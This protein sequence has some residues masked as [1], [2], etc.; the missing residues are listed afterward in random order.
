MEENEALGDDKEDEIEHVEKVR[1]DYRETQPA[2]EA[3]NDVPLDNTDLLMLSDKR[4][5]YELLQLVGMKKGS[6]AG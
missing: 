5:Q 3:T 4:A 1:S 6:E 2:K